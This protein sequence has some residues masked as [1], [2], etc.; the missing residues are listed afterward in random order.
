MA[1]M[2]VFSLGGCV[3]C[4]GGP[5]DYS[6]MYVRTVVGGRSSIGVGYSG[7]SVLNEP[8]ALLAVAIAPPGCEAVG[9][10]AVPA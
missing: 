4:E 1:Y 5:A 9:P 3:L 6:C 7:S 10:L 2:I 8:E